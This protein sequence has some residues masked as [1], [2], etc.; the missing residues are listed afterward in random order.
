APG[1]VPPG[2]G[3]RDPRGVPRPRIHLEQRGTQRSLLELR[4]DRPVEPALPGVMPRALVGGLVA[5]AGVMVILA[6][7][8][9]AP[10]DQASRRAASSGPGCGSRSSSARGAP[11]WW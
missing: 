9:G 7:V 11:G 8:D 5:L 10:F 3:P 4:L 1:L 6:A 2:G